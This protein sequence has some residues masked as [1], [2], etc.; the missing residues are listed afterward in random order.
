MR[1]EFSKKT[2]LAAFQRCNGICEAK[3]CGVKLTPGKYT[4]DH[5][6]PDQLG[7]EPTLENCQVICSACDKAKTRQDAGDIAKAR[8]R[9]Y[10]HIGIKKP[11]TITR[12]RRFDG[13]AVFASRER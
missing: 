11:R 2:K 12:W 7:G 6:V 3:N 13:S 10:Q 8:R 1:R 9:N 4:Y 5:R